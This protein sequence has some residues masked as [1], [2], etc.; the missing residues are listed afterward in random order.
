L[1]AEEG[2]TAFPGLTPG[3]IVEGR[4]WIVRVPQLAAVP[5]RLLGPPIGS[6]RVERDTAP[7]DRHPDP[8]LLTRRGR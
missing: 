8:R 1:L 6:L 4:R 3:V 2:H 7:G 5:G